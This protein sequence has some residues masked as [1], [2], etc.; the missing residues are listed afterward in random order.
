ML[1]LVPN[2]GY[3]LTAAD[4]SWQSTNP[5]INDVVF[6]QSGANLIATITFE[7][8]F[9]M[10]ANDVEIPLCINGD[11]ELANYNV[12]GQINV[13]DT[14]ATSSPLDLTF[15]ISA[16]FNSVVV[17]KTITLSADS[18]FYFPVEPTLVQTVGDASIFT[19]TS[20]KVFDINGNLLSKT[21]VISCTVP[22]YNSL[23]NIFEASAIAFAINAPL[24]TIVDSFA[25]TYLLGPQG[26]TTTISIIGGVGASWTL[27]CATAI[28]LIPDLVPQPPDTPQNIVNTISGV[29]DSSGVS[30]VTI[31]VPEVFAETTYTVD[32]TGDLANPYTGVNPLIF[33]QPDEI[34]VTFTTTP[35]A[36]YQNSGDIQNAGFPYTVPT[37]GMV[38][39][40]NDFTWDI[41]HIDGYGIFLAVPNINPDFS[42]LD[43]LTNGGTNFGADT[44][45]ISQ[46]SGSLIQISVQNGI[47]QYGG[48]DVTS[49]LDVSEFIAY[50]DTADASN[51][52]QTTATSGGNI[53][54]T[55]SSGVMGI[56]GLCYSTSPLPTI[57]NSDI[58]GGTGFGA[59]T[60][61]LI[62]LL[63]GT[64][65]FT[66]AYAYNS[67][68]TIVSYGPEKQFT[69]TV[70]P[71]IT[72]PTVTTASVTNATQ[73][74]A[75]SGGISINANGGTISSRGVQWSSTQNF[76]TILG[77]T[78]DGTGTSN[79]VSAI[80]GLTANT[81][82]WVRAYV[83]NEVATGY[84]TPISFITAETVILNNFDYIIVTYQY[85]PPTGVDYDL[86]TLTTF[87][88][89]TSTLAG[90]TS[91]NTTGFITGT[92]VVGCGAN[93]NAPAVP[94]ASTL[95]NAYLYFG[96]DDSGQ[97][98]DGAYGESVVINFK[99]LSTSGLL[100]SNDVIA[101]GFGG[102]HSGTAGPYP[103][104]IKYETFIGGTI[105]RYTT[106]GGVLTN[107]FVSDGTIV[108]ATTISDPINVIAGTCG[109]G[110][111]IKRR[112]FS[113]AYNV[114]TDAASISFLSY[115]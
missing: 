77:S 59:F 21:F 91:S 47:D 94:T 85:N 65:Y 36:I 41:T 90:T 68:N 114:L 89:P 101:E 99:N 86:D 83:T 88:Y 50:V 4:F 97:S 73:T 25:P 31:I 61:N 100:T 38:G 11:A 54:F 46:A 7:S 112:M 81:T 30:S 64:T 14:N 69:T 10:P 35:N 84:G 57:A 44:I 102:W 96:G 93:G 105:T 82:Y 51:I 70:I 63:P 113:I 106:P 78:S 60:S 22:N 53:V 42:N 39:F 17:A 92:G 23:G 28:F 48:I 110:V 55:G 107:R 15:N 67:E 32:L 26:D 24:D 108:A 43:E 52:L 33:T 71:P 20:S 98:V 115:P 56:R 76:A 2:P 111:D 49:A 72:A 104:S 40:A 58:P 12:T 37:V 87:R 62:N 80:T 103:I 34:T 45:A 1:T 9:V 13:T 109:Q 95:N 8:T 6:T 27:T 29:I 19:I 66:R 75:D 5:Y 16:N 3:S 18:N 74:T 79:Y